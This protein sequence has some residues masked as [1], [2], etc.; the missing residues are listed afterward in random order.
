MATQASRTYTNC[1]FAISKWEIDTLTQ[2]CQGFQHGCQMK[3]AACD[4]PDEFVNTHVGSAGLEQNSDRLN[5]TA[6][7]P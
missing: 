1:E 4:A 5:R 2:S 6:R 3:G 7:G